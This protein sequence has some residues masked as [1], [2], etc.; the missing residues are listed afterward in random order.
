MHRSSLKVIFVFIFILT[1]LFG[2]NLSIQGVARDNTG[3]SL[4]DGA[5]GFTFRLYSNMSGGS[6][7]WTEDQ[8][9]N[10]LNGVFSTILGDMTPM[11]GLNF[12][13]QYFLSLEIDGNGELAPRTKLILSPYAIM[14]GLSGTNVVPESGNVGIGTTQPTYPLDFGGIGG[15]KMEM[16]PGSVT[17]SAGIFDGWGHNS[18]LMGTF[19]DGSSGH[20]FISTGYG[21]GARKFSIGTGTSSTGANAAFKPL[22]TVKTNGSVGIGTD[23]P[24]YPLHIAKPGASVRAT[25]ERSDNSYESFIQFRTGGANKALFGFDND[26]DDL[27]I[28]SYD[29]ADRI[30]TFNNQSGDVGIGDATP[31]AKLDVNGDLMINSWANQSLAANGY[32]QMGGLIMQW[33]VF[34]CTLDNSQSVSFPTTFP[35]ACFGVYSNRKEANVESP[36]TVNS[37]GTSSFTVDRDDGVSGSETVNWFA[38]GH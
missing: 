27:S 1:G 8:N 28:Y 7:V 32:V 14:A 2:Q 10:V 37:W 38:V 19:V 16:Y 17:N 4:P 5:Y 33:G 36:I 26:M 29:G 34:E 25:F 21:T 18:L 24:L 20:G 23:N 30:I 11:S 3:Q 31:D 9:L 6:Q 13:N 12:N 22:L 35:N 15:V